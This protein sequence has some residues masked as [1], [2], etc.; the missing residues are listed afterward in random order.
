MRRHSVRRSERPARDGPPAV[1]RPQTAAIACLAV[2][3]ASGT[4]LMR[5]S[6]GAHDRLAKRCN[7]C[8]HRRWRC[9]CPHGA[10][11]AWGETAGVPPTKPS[12]NTSRRERHA[13]RRPFGSSSMSAIPRRCRAPRARAARYEYEFNLRLAKAIERDLLAAGFTRTVLMVTA[14]PPRR[15]L[16]KRVAL[17]DGPDG[18][19]LPLHPPRFGAELVPGEMG[20]RRPGAVS[21][22]IASAAIPSSSPTTTARGMRASRS[23]DC[24]A[25]N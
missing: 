4:S 5:A 20:V 1:R 12:R 11:T 3:G 10:T 23:A 16:F 17:R 9:C 6:R 24:S 18:R 21:I 22:A 15:G 25:C 7:G 19:S 2:A 14:E 13:I 8:G